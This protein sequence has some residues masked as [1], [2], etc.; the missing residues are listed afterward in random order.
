MAEGAPGVKQAL[1]ALHVGQEADDVYVCVVLL[2]GDASCNPQGA[3]ISGE[4]TTFSKQLHRLSAWSCPKGLFCE[5]T[6]AAKTGCTPQYQYV[7]HGGVEQSTFESFSQ[8]PPHAGPDAILCSHSV[9]QMLTP[10][11]SNNL[12]KIYIIVF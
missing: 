2:C 5:R 10:F 8:V 11:L 6:F 12:T 3:G 9:R 4:Q 7:Q 1:Q